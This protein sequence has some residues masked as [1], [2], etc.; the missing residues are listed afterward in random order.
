MSLLTAIYY[1]SAQRFAN[2]D[3]T[4]EMLVDEMKA[5]EWCLIE[6]DYLRLMHNTLA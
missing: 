4:W 6:K 5:F 2:F 3:N 1:F